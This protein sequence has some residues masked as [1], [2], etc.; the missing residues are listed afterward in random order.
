MSTWTL[1][2]L[3]MIGS[4]LG[5]APAAC[6]EGCRVDGDKA[7]AGE[8]DGCDCLGGDDEEGAETTEA[9]VAPRTD[10]RGEPDAKY[11]VR[12]RVEMLPIAGRPQTEFVAYHEAIPEFK[13]FD[14][15]LGMNEMSMPFPLAKGL[16]VSG[17]KIGD[18][19]EI[20][21]GVWMQ[22]RNRHMEAQRIKKLPADTK[23]NIKG[24]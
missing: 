14:G 4:V 5:L 10:G 16:D 24:G 8:K 11:I 2:K 1:L 20:E 23:L 18:I 13:R 21:F 7:R 15:K 12:G 22:P 9:P 17:L 19:V 3:L 6:D